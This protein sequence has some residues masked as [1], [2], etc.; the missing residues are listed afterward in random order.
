MVLMFQVRGRNSPLRPKQPAQVRGRNQRPVFSDGGLRWRQGLHRP[1]RPSL[2]VMNIVL[3][4][5][6]P[7]APQEGHQ[8]S[9]RLD[10]G[11]GSFQDVLQL[12]E[13]AAAL[14]LAAVRARVCDWYGDG[15][16]H[17]VVQ[18]R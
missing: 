4:Q 14:P 7:S 6:L 11:G 8:L 12:R 1:Q 15:G 10:I 2:G 3:S 9:F 16:G 17:C 13:Q 18:P 5:R